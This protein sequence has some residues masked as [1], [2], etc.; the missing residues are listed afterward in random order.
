[1]T[2]ADPGRSGPVVLDP[3]VRRLV[4][5]SAAPPY[6]HEIGPQDG[7]QALLES[8]GPAHRDPAVSVEFKVAPT[9]PS[10]LV[11]FWIFQPTAATGTPGVVVYAHGGRWM[12][13]DAQ[14]HSRLITDLV[15]LSGQAFVVPEYTR[16]PEARYP[17]ALEEI[18]ALLC[19]LPANAA[20]L[21][22]DA[23][24]PA[25]AGD[26]A[27][28]TMAAALTI[29]AKRRSGPRIRA[30]LLYYPMLD[31]GC[32][33]ASHREFATGYLL[34]HEAV[35]W[36]WEQYCDD[37]RELTEA[38]V[39]PLRASVADLAGLP[40]ALIIGA[41]ADPVRDEGEAYA[42]RLRE[43]GVDATAV[44]YQGT[45]HDFASLT[46]L[47]AMS[48]ARLAVRQGADFLRRETRQ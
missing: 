9:G 29:L 14:T 31:A 6:L 12:L 21:G 18:Y 7:R 13:G 22:V 23:R 27:G 1:M 48:P 43:A 39:S 34:T 20:E 32:E 46:A 40:P 47:R 37:P 26:C 5:A 17:V 16:T 36:Y 30:Q 44:R 2:S 8:Q 35:R 3:A 25:V 24:R 28:A 10:G 41:E 4:A 45:V 33:L 11:G 19:W 38:T 15:I 42:A